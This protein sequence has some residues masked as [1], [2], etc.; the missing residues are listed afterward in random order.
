M[1]WVRSRGHEEEVGWIF[2][3]DTDGLGILGMDRVQVLHR[4][5]KC[6]GFGLREVQ[7]DVVFL[8]V[9]VQVDKCRGQRVFRF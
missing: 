1:G 9:F 5:R 7:I 2:E 4:F 3:L 6:S 8:P